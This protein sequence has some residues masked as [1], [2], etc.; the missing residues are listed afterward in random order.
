LDC[1]SWDLLLFSDAKKPSPWLHPAAVFESAQGT[2]LRNAAFV[3]APF[4]QTGRV[5]AF[6][7]SAIRFMMQGGST[8][9]IE[10]RPTAP[11]I[12]AADFRYQIDRRSGHKPT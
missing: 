7:A 9:E 6:D 11:N 1:S 4:R 10:R 12:T 2:L 8:F 5:I 3:N